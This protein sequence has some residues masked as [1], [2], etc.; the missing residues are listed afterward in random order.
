M[1]LTEIIATY[2]QQGFAITNPRLLK[3][4]KEAKVYVVDCLGSQYALKVYKDPKERSFKQ[5]KVYLDGMYFRKPSERKAISKRS[6]FGLRLLN[7]GWVR[8]EFHMLQKMYELG[9]NVPQ[10]LTWTPQTVLMEFLGDEEAAPRLKDVELSMEQAQSAFEDILNSLR[11]FFD[12]GIVHADLSAFNILWWK[13]KPYIIDF[14]QAI[15]VRNNP[16]RDML[17]RRDIDNICSY[18]ERYFEIDHEQIY[19]EFGLSS[20]N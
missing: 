16:N 6:S 5:N 9:A 2:E 20:G 1:D 17:L 13:N 10:I 12:N 15:D 19:Q 8:R 14:P 7:K 3:S 11:I 4:G 18:F